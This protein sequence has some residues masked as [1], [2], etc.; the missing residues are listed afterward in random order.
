MPSTT[1][2][3]LNGLTTSVAVKAPCRVATTANITLS[4]LQSIDGVT[5]VAGDRVLVKNQTTTTENGVYEASA[6]AWV[7]AADFDGSLDV[8]GGTLLGV[9]TGTA[10]ADSYWRVVGDGEKLPGT[11]AITFYSIDL[12]AAAAAA[13]AD[14]SADAASASATAADASADAAAASALAAD[15]SADA[16]AASEAVIIAALLSGG[17]FTDTTV[18]AAITAG[19]AA[20]ADGSFFIATGDDIDEVRQ[21]KDVAG[22]ATL[23]FSL[24]KTAV[25][26][27]AVAAA[28]LASTTNYAQA[29]KSAVGSGTLNALFDMDAPRTA[30]SSSTT[31]MTAIES[32]EGNAVSLTI[33]GTLY[34]GTDPRPVYT[35]GRGIYLSTGTG[36]QTTADLLPD[37]ASDFAMLYAVDLNTLTSTV[38]T[39]AGLP[40]SPTDGELVLVNLDRNVAVGLGADVPIVLDTDWTAANLVNGYYRYSTY[41]TAWERETYL[42]ATATT[43]TSEF[44]AKLTALGQLYVYIYDGSTSV[45]LISKGSVVIGQSKL[46][47]AIRR[48]GDLWSLVVNGETVFGIGVA[49]SPNVT[50]ITEWYFHGTGRNALAA[51]PVSGAIR[52]Y[53]MG[54]TIAT[55]V[56]D[57]TAFQNLHDTFAA[58]HGGKLLDVPRK[59]Y[60]VA[61]FGQSWTTGTT[62]VTDAW[63]HGANNWNGEVSNNN[64]S[65]YQ[66]GVSITRE[67]FS[68]VLA[69]R[70]SDT[71]WDIAPIHV[72]TDPSGNPSNGRSHIG[73][74]G[75]ENFLFGWAKQINTH[76]MGRNADWYMAF[77]A[78]GGASVALLTAQTITPLMSQ[79]KSAP[80]AINDYYLKMLRQIVYQRDMA[81]AKGQRFT[82]PLVLW[83]QGH[84]D[85]GNSAYLT[86]LRALY[87]KFCV[88]VMQITGQNNKPF[89]L[90]PQ[91]NYSIDGTTNTSGAIDQLFLD[92]EDQRSISLPTGDT[93]PRPLFCIGPMYQ[94]TNFIHPYLSGHVWIGELFGQATTR[95]LFDGES[96]AS[97]RPYAYTYT[98]GGTTIDIDY[99]VRTGRSLVTNATNANQIP[100]AVTNAGFVFTDASGGGVTI[101]SVAATDA[102]TI[103]V[104]LSGAIG[105]G[106]TISYLGATHRTGNVADGAAVDGIYRDQDWT[107]AFTAGEPTFKTTTGNYNDLRQW[108]AASKKVLS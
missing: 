32:L 98:L 68:N 37:M 100:A 57:D 28:V 10:N 106:D 11:D 21:Y 103:R 90:A 24:P 26:T 70:D 12:L 51:L 81:E 75:T 15:A 87:D 2:D 16:A 104:T 33:P 58:R 99:R 1:T 7:R 66:E 107:V 105:T 63:T 91:I 3:R 38:G 80:L 108:A 82:V 60:G 76:E 34:S 84:T 27:D 31:I 69:A 4:G 64:N 30:Y 39:V 102:D 22:V 50:D 53:W 55:D 78:T 5:V 96:Y 77:D 42:F 65:Y 20:T 61:V 72:S 83:Q 49:T 101:S 8:V 35:P 88:D 19:L 97:L 36:F 62:A 56:P 46:I 48:K 95:V 41:Y 13:A 52:H 25:L 73:G 67:P 45:T 23:I 59:A 14:V 86:E 43:G 89:L 17:A 54:V 40:G 74:V 71:P 85:Q 29:M 9:N 44:F 93:V 92:M 6:S 79:L 18:A 47:F 94:I